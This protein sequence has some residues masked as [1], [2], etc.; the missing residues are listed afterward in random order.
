MES[1]LLAVGMLLGSGLVALVASKFPRASSAV[2]SAGAVSGCVIGLVATARVLLGG[3]AVSVQFHWSVPGGP[4]SMGIDSLSAFFL[5]P[6]FALSALAAIYGAAYLQSYAARKSLGP[7]AFFFN[8]LVA[9]MVLVV[10]A[11]NGLVFLVA[12]ELMSL[13]AYFLVT[14]EH[15]K[16]DVRRA[17]W[18]YL[19][20]THLG[21]ACLFA[22]FL[23]L[24]RPAGSLEFDGY[25]QATT[26]GAGWMATFSFS[27]SSA[28]GPKRDLCRGT[29]GCP[30]RIQPRRRTCRPSCRA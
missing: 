11:R 26:L 10:I 8:L 29:S 13:A 6:I 20:A 3:S 25:R 18:V 30:K 9:S 15:E 24:G 2:A 23:L 27:R 1:L 21:A 16:D 22:L 12:W 28:S 5:A 19:V 17:G 14:F 7:P 4:F